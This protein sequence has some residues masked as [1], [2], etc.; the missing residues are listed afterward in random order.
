MARDRDESSEELLV[1]DVEV[2]AARVAA[3]VDHGGRAHGLPVGQ[4][5]PVRP[6][7]ADLGPEADPIAE[8]LA[9]SSCQMARR[10]G[11]VAAVKH[12]VP[13]GEA[14]LVSRPRVLDQGPHPVQLRG[15]NVV[16]VERPGVVAAEAPAPLEDQSSESGRYRQ[17]IGDQAVGE[18]TT[19]QHQVRRHETPTA[20]PSS[21]RTSICMGRRGSSN[22]GRV[23]KQARKSAVAIPIASMGRAL[24]SFLTGS[25][26]NVTVSTLE[27]DRKD[28]D[29]RPATSLD[30]MEANQRQADLPHFGTNRQYRRAG[31]RDK[32]AAWVRVPCPSHVISHTIQ[33]F[34]GLPARARIGS[35]GC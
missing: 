13:V 19:H 29:S 21:P 7:L 35:A 8:H 24:S 30:R 1:A 4:P 32:Q 16:L 25:R 15:G 6:D 22:V 11:V 9:D 20:S 18:A 2:G 31:R 17:A 14:H 26:S 5:H 33:T 28:R 12:A 23:D 10:G 27:S 3:S 34:L